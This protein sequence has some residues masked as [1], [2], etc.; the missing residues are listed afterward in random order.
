MAGTGTEKKSAWNTSPHANRSVRNK[1]ACFAIRLRPA[2]TGH[3][4]Q[5]NHLLEDC[6]PPYRRHVR[7]HRH[8]GSAGDIA[9]HAHKLRDADR[10]IT[11]AHVPFWCLRCNALRIIPS[12]CLNGSTAMRESAASSG[13]RCTMASRRTNFAISSSAFWGT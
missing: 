4:S 7:F 11:C 3:F 13:V 2:Q 1:C 12:C 10:G 9:D 5:N 8:T 6:G